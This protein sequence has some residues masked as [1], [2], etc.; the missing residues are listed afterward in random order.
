MER[1]VLAYSGGLDTSVAI[2]WLK[3]HYQAE[4]VAVTMDLGQ[5][6]ELEA[7]RDRALAIGALRAH[8]LDLREEFAHDFVLPALKADALYDDRSPMTAAL[9]RPLIAQK[10]VEIAEIEQAQAV[11]HGGG[12]TAGASRSTS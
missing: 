9:G 7:V 8:V 1:I 12:G 5:G 2:P 6:R 3:A 11:A 4:I 10:L